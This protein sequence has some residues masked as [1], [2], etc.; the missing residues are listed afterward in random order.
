M[1]QY[2]L[3]YMGQGRL[4]FTS[5]L[6]QKMFWQISVWYFPSMELMPREDKLVWTVSYILFHPPNNPLVRISAAYLGGVVGA[7]VALSVVGQCVVGSGLHWVLCSVGQCIVCSGSG[8]VYSGQCSG[9]WCVVSE[10]LKLLRV[11]RVWESLTS[12]DV[13]APQFLSLLGL[14]YLAS[15]RWRPLSTG[16]LKE[17]SSD[18][19]IYLYAIS[20]KSSKSTSN[21]GFLCRAR[22]TKGPHSPNCQ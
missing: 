16:H 11:T 20:W 6:H 15:C 7:N 19:C 3:D 9:K 10:R 4:V 8:P 18:K 13:L 22:S 12:L 21:P 2:I 14:R 17:Y 1:Y 5:I